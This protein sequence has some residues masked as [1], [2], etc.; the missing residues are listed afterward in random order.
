[1]LLPRFS[2]KEYPLK[3][4]DMDPFVQ[5]TISATLEMLYEEAKAKDKSTS[6]RQWSEFC[7]L[8]DKDAPK[9]WV[10]HPEK[11]K[12]N[13]V[14]KTCEYFSNKLDCSITI[15]YL[16]DS[17]ITRNSTHDA[18]SAELVQHVYGRLDKHHKML[19]TS[20]L[21]EFARIEMIETD[22]RFLQS[23]LDSEP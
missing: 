12:R 5:K 3:S 11:M 8:K 23:A 10:Q 15:D 9:R 7:G 16:R 21:K 2:E 6:Y 20:M 4:D 19:V 13:K 22:Y 1:M 14:L 17:S 18:W